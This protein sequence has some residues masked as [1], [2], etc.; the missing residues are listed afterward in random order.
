MT[1]LNWIL[2]RGARG[3][4]TAL[5]LTSCLLSAVLA[6]SQTIDPPGPT[7][8]RELQRYAVALED[9]TLYRNADVASDTILEFRRGHIFEY[10]G[11]TA[12]TFGRDW[13]SVGSGDGWRRA[14]SWYAIPA[15]RAEV[16]DVTGAVSVLRSLPA[17]PAVPADEFATSETAAAYNASL[18]E[19]ITVG[20]YWWDQSLEVDAAALGQFGRVVGVWARLVPSDVAEELVT[21]L[22]GNEVLGPWPLEP[23]FGRLYVAPRTGFVY[24]FDGADWRLMDPPL[25][26]DSMMGLLGNPQ[27]SFDREVPPEATGR[28]ISCWRL[29]G[30]LTP[31]GGL[32]GGV[33]AAPTPPVRLEATTRLET[34]RRLGY[35]N[36]TA[37]AWPTAAP[38]TRAPRRVLPEKLAEGVL[39]SDTSRRQAVY[40]EQVIPG[41]LTRQLRGRELR[42]RLMA[43]AAGGEGAAV[44]TVALEV[45]AGS[46]R[47]STSAQVGVLPTPVELNLVIPE[48][49]Q[50]ITVRVLPTDV[51]IAVLE[52]GS[53]VIDSATL[54]PAEWPEMSEATPLL[55][56]R[57]RAVT[58]RPAPRYTRAT[59]VISRRSPEQLNAIWREAEALPVERLEKIL[60]GEVEANMT[61]R[62]VQLAWGEPTKVTAGDLTRWV[63]SDRAASFDDTGVLL[64]WSRQ[65]EQE[66]ARA[67]VCGTERGEKASEGRE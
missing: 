15:T 56:R 27:L 28:P 16:R 21:M 26:M 34:D 60:S 25:A 23:A 35:Y 66:Q 48:D 29:V 40:L 53:V 55:L 13:H 2:P 67:S 3:G 44:A 22:G 42:A 41:S 63:W 52:S 30:G 20:P 39:L 1:S 38:A 57:V 10:L 24:R 65:T 46:V 6:A 7:L 31:R 4:V 8:V 11:E 58:Y 49:A 19:A 17:P 9:G 14:E 61:E 50:T 59:L 32:A 64:A 18:K 37:R 33:E 5:A 12:D 45:E 47:Q 43:R 36:L 51:S 54:V 62:Q